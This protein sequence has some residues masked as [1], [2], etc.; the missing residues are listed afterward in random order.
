MGSV[1]IQSS[2]VAS[3]KNKNNN[4]NNYNSNEIQR[5]TTNMVSLLRDPLV[6]SLPDWVVSILVPLSAISGIVF[7]LWLWYRVSLVPVRGFSSRD[8]GREYLLEEEQGAESEVRVGE[9]SK[10]DAVEPIGPPSGGSS[11][12]TLA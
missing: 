6:V 3:D 1:S 12:T 10:I 2:D 7:A 4:N 9:I 11:P 5:V 8:G